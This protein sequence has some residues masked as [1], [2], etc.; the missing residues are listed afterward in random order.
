MVEIITLHFKY[1]KCPKCNSKT[2][3]TQEIEYSFA[4]QETYEVIQCSN[5]KCDFKYKFKY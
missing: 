4:D 3:H 2:L 1:K 5:I